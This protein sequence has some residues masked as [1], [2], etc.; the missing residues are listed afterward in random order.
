MIYKILTNILFQSISIISTPNPPQ[1]INCCSV[2]NLNSINN[3][4]VFIKI[5]KTIGLSC[6]ID[7][8]N[9]NKNEY[10]IFEFFIFIRSFKKEFGEFK[11]LY[12]DLKI[13]SDCCIT[14]IDTSNIN[15]E[16]LGIYLKQV[17]DLWYKNFL[18]F[19][20]KSNDM[21]NDNETGLKEFKSSY[22]IIT[23]V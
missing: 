6:Q 4:D 7:V 1:I 12:Y 13:Q 22:S 11:Q 14:G 2:Y 15:S 20:S 17:D 16:N 19:L 10:N 23:N 21:I 5:F 9:R 3:N 18:E 8:Y